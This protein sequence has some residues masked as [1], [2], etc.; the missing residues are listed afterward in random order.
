MLINI[1]SII[2][3]CI[4]QSLKGASDNVNNGIL[5]IA[6]F[7][8]VIFVEIYYFNPTIGEYERYVRIT[9]GA[10]LFLTIAIAV[11]MMIKGII[12]KCRNRNKKTDGAA[13][14]NDSKKKVSDKY[15]P[16]SKL[17]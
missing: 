8:N 1:I 14:E 5:E 13:P 4:T 10:L 11:Y 3:I 16:S 7:V 15:K 17:S 6:T 12:K 2:H 9:T